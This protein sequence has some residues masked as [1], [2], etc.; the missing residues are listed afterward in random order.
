MLFMLPLGWIFCRKMEAWFTAKRKQSLWNQNTKTKPWSKI[1]ISL[2]PKFN[3]SIGF[4][5]LMS[6]VHPL[7][8]LSGVSSDHIGLGPWSKLIP[9][10]DF[11]LIRHID[12]CVVDDMFGPHRGYITPLLLCILPSPPHVIV[13]VWTVS[14]QIKQR[15]EI[16][17]Y[18]TLTE[19]TQPLGLREYLACHQ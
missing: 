9:G 1:S 18:C 11:N 17:K 12:F 8:V 3:A 2:S 16:N 4:H 13:Q 6:S 5:Q 19:E 15:L 10:L 7:T 14:L